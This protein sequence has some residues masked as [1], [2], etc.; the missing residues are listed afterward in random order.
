MC[1]AGDSLKIHND[2]PFTTKDRNNNACQKNCKFQFYGV[3]WFGGGKNSNL[4]GKYTNDASHTNPNG[5]NW[6]H[7]KKIRYYSLKRASMK[8]RPND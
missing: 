4:N 6:F 8:I 7:W 5:I 3:W 2:S 1:L